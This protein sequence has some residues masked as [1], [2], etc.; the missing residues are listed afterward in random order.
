MEEFDTINK[1]K[2]YQGRLG[3]EAISVV[4]NFMSEEQ[5]IGF[6]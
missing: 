6:T 5:L 3:L 4:E 2:H 1:P